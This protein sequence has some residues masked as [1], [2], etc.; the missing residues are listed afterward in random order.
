MP[1]DEARICRVTRTREETRA[2]YDRISRWYDPLEGFWEGKP[3]QVGLQKLGARRGEVVLGLGFGTGHGILALARSVGESGRVYGIDLSPRMFEL[4]QIRASQNGLAER[5]ELRI[6]DATALPFDA[7]LFHAV[8][9]SFVLELFDTPE[10][11]L[12]LS[13]CRRVLKNGGR[14][15]VVSLSKTGRSSWMRNLY[16]WGH[17]K[18][19]SLLDCRPIFAQAALR[20]AGFETR[21]TS[22]MFL[23]GLPVEIVVGFK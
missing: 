10:I 18:F 15:C 7:D 13:E 4:S 17:D 6:G 20:A 8:F 21:E 12:V 9:A 14:V 11:P 19:P 22:R 5:V 2:A 3:K 1:K 23:W 16:E